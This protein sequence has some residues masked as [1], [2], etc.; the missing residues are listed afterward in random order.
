MDVAT[1]HCI[2]VADCTGGDVCCGTY[3]LTQLTAAT[4][5]Q[6]KPPCSF[7]QFCR[8]SAEC[9][10]G[11]QCIQQSCAG[12]ANVHLCGLQTDPLYKCVAN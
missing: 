9:P 5:C 11:V 1:F 8:T 10:S 6:A 7:A 12:G 2:G 3:D 4:V